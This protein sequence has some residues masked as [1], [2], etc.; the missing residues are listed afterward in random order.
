MSQVHS[1]CF[2]ATCI[3]AIALTS[4]VH[5]YCVSATRNIAIALI[6]QVQSSKIVALHWHPCVPLHLCP[7]G[8]GRAL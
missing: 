8:T 7:A 5:S 4:Q 6:S 1:Y 3:I 2:S